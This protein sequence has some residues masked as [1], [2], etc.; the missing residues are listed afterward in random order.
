MKKL[1]GLKTIVPNRKSKMLV[2]VCIYNNSIQEKVNFIQ[3]KPLGFK[4]FNCYP[5]LA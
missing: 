4:F 1:V 3:I 2:M 5:I